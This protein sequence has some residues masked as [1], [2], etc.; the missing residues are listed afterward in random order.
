MENY[1]YA[2][3][4]LAKRSFSE[5]LRG[6]RVSDIVTSRNTLVNRLRRDLEESSKKWGVEIVNVKVRG[7]KPNEK[8]KDVTHLRL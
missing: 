3:N 4:E 5:A 6:L 1:L 8:Q 2:M 7:L